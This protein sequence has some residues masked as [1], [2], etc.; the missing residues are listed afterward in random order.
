MPLSKGV[1]LRAA[2]DMETIKALILIN[3]G[4]AVAVAAGLPAVLSNTRFWELALPMMSGVLVFAVGLAAAVLSNHFR[5]AC[6]LAFEQHRMAP[7]TYPRECVIGKWCFGTSV[8]AF[9]GAVLLIDGW[10]MCIVLRT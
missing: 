4:G 8:A 3:G 10:G 1:E 9:L 2:M 6:S 5:R 7:P